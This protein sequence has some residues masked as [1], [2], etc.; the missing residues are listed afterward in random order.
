MSVRDENL[1]SKFL[2]FSNFEDMLF[3]MNGLNVS[4]VFGDGRDVL[5]QLY[6]YH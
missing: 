5:N 6:T 4:N 2:Y 3:Q 1:A